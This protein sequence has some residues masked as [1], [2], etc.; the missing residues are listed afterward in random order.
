MCGLA[1]HRYRHSFF[2]LKIT[3]TPF[4][5]CDQMFLRIGGPFHKANNILSKGT[6][7]E[8]VDFKRLSV[9]KS[10]IQRAMRDITNIRRRLLRLSVVSL[11]YDLKNIV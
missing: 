3:A 10:S 6:T 5:C 9:Q 2:L 7:N 11:F 8:S 4:A 1:K